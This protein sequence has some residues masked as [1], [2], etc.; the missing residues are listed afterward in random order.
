MRKLVR[1]V[2][3]ALLSVPFFLKWPYVV[4]QWAVRA[5][6]VPMEK[7]QPLLGWCLGG[8]FSLPLL[9]LQLIFGGHMI[10]MLPLTTWYF[11]CGLRAVYD[12]IILSREYR[13]LRETPL[14]AD[15]RPTS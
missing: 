12:G 4:W 7:R 13:H 10:N 5:H 9:A 6:H 15:Y 11:S 8:T 2:G 1:L 14:L 3:L